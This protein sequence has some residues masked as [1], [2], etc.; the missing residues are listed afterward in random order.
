MDGTEQLGYGVD[1][2]E[3]HRVFKNEIKFQGFCLRRRREYKTGLFSGETP[4][5]DSPPPSLVLG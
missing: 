2:D 3:A 1:L 5:K 4:I